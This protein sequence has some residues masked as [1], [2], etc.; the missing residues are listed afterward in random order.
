MGGGEQLL[1]PPAL[2]GIGLTDLQRQNRRP[3]L[4]GGDEGGILARRELGTEIA[5]A[6]EGTM[7]FITPPHLGPI[8]EL[9]HAPAVEGE[10]LLRAAKEQAER[11]Q[12]PRCR[13]LVL[14]TG[15]GNFIRL[16]ERRAH[17]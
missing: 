6:P 8:E 14:F 1:A 13:D 10:C 2:G 4:G 15:D 12:V 17:R 3:W 11:W 16:P 9:T 7:G 5:W